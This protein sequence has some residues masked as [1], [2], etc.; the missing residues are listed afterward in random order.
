MANPPDAWVEDARNLDNAE[1]LLHSAHGILLETPA[2]ADFLRNETNKRIVVAPKG[3][4]KT[5][6]LKSKRI[7]LQQMS[8]NLSCL[9]ENQLVDATISDSP[10]LSQA[11]V[12]RFVDYTFWCQVWSAALMLS[13]VKSSAKY[14]PLDPDDFRS[15]V[16]RQLLLSSYPVSPFDALKR[17]INSDREFQQ[18]RRSHD[19]TTLMSYYR[20]IRHP[21]AVFVDTIDE[22]F[23]GYVSQSEV[24]ADASYVHR[25]KDSRIWI[26]GQ[27]AGC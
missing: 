20:Q 25:N 26:V 13:V 10:S 6:L 22:Y 21:V 27:L 17:L 14:Y 24:D 23:E 16:M 15:A 18:A 12:Q 5:F 8:E 9:P 1:Q 2:I 3:Y 7:L 4:G 11:D 19:L